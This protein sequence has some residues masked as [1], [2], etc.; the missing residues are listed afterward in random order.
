MIGF[1]LSVLWGLVGCGGEKVYPIFD[2]EQ[3]FM[4]FPNDLMFSSDPDQ[5][6]TLYAGESLFNP[7]IA[8]IDGLDGASVI[9]QIDIPFSGSLDPT[10]PLL[11]DNFVFEGGQWVPNQNQNIYLVPLVYPG[12]DSLVT[13][14]VYQDNHKVEL[15]HPG[16]LQ[17]QYFEQM[18]S[19]YMSEEAQKQLTAQRIRPEIISLD[20]GV[21]NVLRLT[22]LA[23]L[24][25]E[26]KYLLVVTSDIESAEGN[27]T[28]E[29]A[30]YALLSD[31]EQVHDGD[32]ANSLVAPAV[33]QWE[34]LAKQYFQQSGEYS[35]SPIDLSA[36]EIVLAYSFTTGG[37]ASVLGSIAAPEVFFEKRLAVAAKQ[38][39]IKKLA[40]GTYILDASNTEGSGLVDIEIQSLLASLLTC[41]SSTEVNCSGVLL[42]YNPFYQRDIAAKIQR[43]SNHYTDFLNSP[44]SL[45]ILQRAVA[46]AALTIVNESEYPIAEQ[47]MSLVTELE[48]L[49]PRPKPRVTSF[50]RA[51][52][53][54]SI[55]TGC[56]D[57]INPFFPAPAKVSQGQITLPYYLATPIEEDGVT[58]PMPIVQRAWQAQEELQQH[59]DVPISD[60]ITYRFPFPE[61]QSSVTVPLLSIYPDEAV[62]S[63]SGQ[64]KPEAGWPV[65]IYQHGITTSR[66]TALPMGDAFAFS[67]VD[68]SDSSLSTP[69][70]VPCFAT[71]AIDQA[72]HGIDTNGSLML[73]NVN[74]P[75]QPIVPNMGLN[76]P[77]DELRERHFSYTAN[78]AGLPIPM[79]YV[80]DIGEPGSLFINLASFLTS[81]DNMRQSAVDLMNLTASLAS[82]DIDGDGVLPDLD[83]SQVYFIA[84]SL[85]G[86]NGTPFLASVNNADT[87]RLSADVPN[88]NAA[89]LLNVGGGV[90]KLLENLPDSGFGAQVV[91]P[92]L[93]TAGLH[94][95]TSEFELFMSVLQGT[96]D[97]IDAMNFAREITE[98]NKTGILLTE[99]VGGGIDLVPDLDDPS[100][101]VLA[102]VESD[103][104]IQNDSDANA[105]PNTAI[106]PFSK[107]LDDGF[108]I[109]GLP[110]PL[111][112]SEPL[113]QQFSAISTDRIQLDGNPIVAVTRFT[114]GSHG[115][116]VNAGLQ[117]A[118]GRIF[119]RFSS[120]D[121][122]V[123]IVREIATL[124]ASEGRYT[125]ITD[126]SVVQ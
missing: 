126:Q 15:E 117:V 65:I 118:G 35:D 100:Q 66:S 111:A 60:K 119:D 28:H 4:P 41:P 49:L 9:A 62:L 36:K 96:L 19:G 32:S 113:I 90:A 29:S 85:G 44:S 109:S 92:Q 6:G 75:D 56:A 99:I 5:D 110:A 16:F 73:F 37:T 12:G 103:Q 93:A 81:R 68:P 58:N 95:G 48:P 22:P 77:S 70:G 124:F 107:V 108:V 71:V 57:P 74:D 84:Y 122:Y 89:A 86:I 76:L 26:T 13:T 106:G 98:Q 123:E 97:S 87:Q 64:T 114:K 53:L 63:L 40:N 120:Y 43:G 31:P 45:N 42:E 47:A 8:A 104:T 79:D 69:S 67:C 14:S 52:C 105:W 17:L 21:N 24:V 33:L 116:P 78:D 59:L 38:E 61:Q 121:V 102:E 46:F 115:A 83:V 23:P 101:F 94:Q 112:G 25:P 125:Q 3:N 55:E 30:N 7:V 27:R 91:L 39:A 82:M 1:V 20:G 10:Q 88:I 34:R 18:L 50:Y 51:D 72:L 54:G 11:S 2:A 80:N